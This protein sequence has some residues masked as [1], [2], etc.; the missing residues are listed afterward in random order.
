MRMMDLCQKTTD[1]TDCPYGPEVFNLFKEKKVSKLFICN[2]IFL[3]ID[4]I[5]F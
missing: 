4:F 3:Q 1:E 5:L 2:N